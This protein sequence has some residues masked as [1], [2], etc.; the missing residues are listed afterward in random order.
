MRSWI[1]HHWKANREVDLHLG[2]K[3]FF[4]IVFID[5]EDKDKVFEGGPYF[6]ASARLYMI[7]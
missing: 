5:V 1:K 4:T 7:P 3:G 2:S 6:H